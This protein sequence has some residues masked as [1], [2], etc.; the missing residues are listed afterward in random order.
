MTL[1][2][3]TPIATVSPIKDILRSVSD[4]ESTG[5]PKISE[6]RADRETRTT[7]AKHLDVL[8]TRIN[9]YNNT[10]SQNYT[11]NDTLT[12]ETHILTLGTHV[13]RTKTT[14]VIL[15]RVTHIMHT[16]MYITLSITTTVLHNLRKG[17]PH[18]TSQ[19]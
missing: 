16:E 15:T 9:T 19:V 17:P 18:N 11:R 6:S 3:G 1:L 10:D 8:N 13:I 12:G 4:E 14:L 2:Y 7:Y 5:S